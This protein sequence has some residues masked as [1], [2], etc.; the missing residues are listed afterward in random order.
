MK[1]YGPAQGQAIAV[2]P[3]R[4]PTIFGKPV[5]R[6]VRSLQFGRASG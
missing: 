2:D 6:C 4:R 5:A 1:N 3:L